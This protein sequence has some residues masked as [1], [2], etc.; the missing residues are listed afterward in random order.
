MVTN[1]STVSFER[2]LPFQGCHLNFKSSNK[3][4]QRV[5]H[6]LSFRGLF[7]ALPNSSPYRSREKILPPESNLTPPS[8]IHSAVP[9]LLSGAIINGVMHPIDRAIYVSL[10]QGRS[11]FSIKNYKNPYQF[12]WQSLVFRTFSGGLYFF[13]QQQVG[14]R[15]MPLLSSRYDFTDS[16]ARLMTSGMIGLTYSLITN[17]FSSVKYHIL[18]SDEKVQLRSAIIR[19][20]RN[21]GGFKVFMRGIEATVMRDMVFGIT[22][23]MARHYFRPDR[24]RIVADLYAAT[25]AT[26]ISSPW[27][28]ARF[29]IYSTPPGKSVPTIR[30][31]FRGMLA[32]SQTKIGWDKF[33]FFGK[34]LKLGVG[35]AR[36]GVGFA[37][38]QQIF[39]WSENLLTKLSTHQEAPKLLQRASLG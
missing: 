11:F 20:Q 5:A 23:E 31:I 15:L 35:T 30:E 25:L 24:E 21:A 26:I 32:E 28:Y 17:P 36:M 27:N 8:L 6:T 19:M 9:A 14:A 38:S 2:F 34:R 33:T 29:K 12:F 16:A 1:K 3:R 37:L 10:S 39:D 7:S 13:L 18:S 22:Y 4:E